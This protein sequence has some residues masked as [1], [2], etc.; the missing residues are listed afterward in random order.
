ML[1][2]LCRC[3]RVTAAMDEKCGGRGRFLIM[4]EARRIVFL[5]IEVNPET[6]KIREYGAISSDG[7]Q[8]RGSSAAAFCDLMDGAAYLIG[9]NLLGHDLR[10]L[11]YLIPEH[12][13]DA[14]MIDTLPLSP[15]LFPK[16]PYHRLLKDD[17]L[18][19][20]QINNPLNDAKKARELFEDETAA[21]RN[22]PGAL[23]ALYGRL[24]GREE[25]FSGFM[26]WIGAER[27]YDPEKEIRELFIGQICDHAPLENLIEQVPVELAYAL[28]LIYAGDP[29]SVTPPWV[30]R[31]YPKITNVMKL[32]RGTPCRMRCSYCDRKLDI[33]RRLKEIFGFDA[34]RTYGGVPLQEEATEAAV[35]GESLLAVFPTGGG[36][37]LTFQLPALIAGETDRG[38]TVVI[39]PLQS[40]M[41]DQVDHLEEKGIADA[42]TINGLL[43]PMERKEAI[44][45]VA[46]GL[47]SI[48]YI[49]PESLRSGTIA[50]LLRNR[51]VV[52]FVVDEA[53][54]FSAWGQDFRVDYLYIG[55]FIR[56]LQEEKHLTRAIPVSCFTATAKQKVI[57]DIREYFGKKLGLELKLY[58]TQTARN[59][60]R[61]AVLYKETDEE[62]YQEV[63]NLIQARR[64]PS[65]VY[66]SRVR[67]TEQI[68]GW[69]REDGIAAEAY[70]GRMDSAEKVRVQDAFLSDQVQVIVA[71]SAFGMGVDKKDVGLVIHYDIS[72]S[73][74]NYVQEAGRAGRDQHMN[75]ECYVLFNEE[76]LDKHFI[77]LNQTKLSLGEIQ[78]VWKAVKELTRNRQNV[79]CS[80]LEIARQ[81]GWDDA[82]PQMETRVTSA[83]AALENARYLERGR[84]VPHIYASSIQVPDMATAVKQL[85]ASGRFSEEQRNTARRIMNYLISRK[86]TAKGT[87]DE[88]ESRVDYLADRLGLKR[89]EVVHSILLMR[90][91]GMLADHTDLTAFIRREENRN[92]SEWI[93]RRFTV[94]ETFMLDHM[95]DGE[96]V[97]LRELNDRAV[98]EGIRTATVRQMKTI[99]FFWTI[100]GEYRK[101]LSAD[102]ERMIPERAMD[103]DTQRQRVRRRQS[104]C[105][106]VVRYLFGKLERCRDGDEQEDRMV[107]FSVKELQ[108]AFN[109]PEDQLTPL[110]EASTEDV[111]QALL[112]LSKIQALTLDGGFLVAYNAMQIHRL[113]MDN[114]I[115][116]KADDYRLLNE[117]YRQRVQ[118]IHI[119]GEYAHLM[120][121][122]YD[123][124]LR[125]VSDYFLMDYRGFLAKY[126]KGTRK[127]EIN[128]NITPE[129][130]EKL[131]GSLSDV[132]REIVDDDQSQRIV[133]AAGPGSG[134]TRLL[135]H[136]LASLMMLED[137][138]HEQMLMLT[139]SRAAATEFKSRLLA[140]I[141]NAAHFVEIRTF[142]SYCFDLLGRIGNLEETGTVVRSAAEMIRSGEV[143]NG[144]ITRSVLV[145]DEAQDMDADENALVQALMKRNENM[146][147]I[148]V[149]DDD[150]NIFGFRGSSSAYMLSLVADAGARMT[151]MTENYRSDR[152]LVDMANAFAA[153]IRHRVKKEKIRAVSTETGRV[154]VYRYDGGCLE[155][156]L[157]ERLEGHLGEGSVCV[158]TQTNEQAERV[159][160][161]LRHRGIRCGLIQSNDGFPLTNLAEIRF[162]FRQLEEAGETILIEDEKWN[163]ARAKLAETWSESS[164]LPLC[165]NLL[166]RF[167]RVNRRKYRRD[168]EEYLRESDMED[169]QESPAGQ[170]T[171]ST[172]H[173]A[174]GREF[175]HVT[176]LLTGP[177]PREDEDRRK[178][179]VGLT[180]AKKSLDIH[181]TWGIFDRLAFPGFSLTRDGNRREEPEAILLRLGHRDV[182]LGFFL[183]RKA[184]N[185]RL[186]PGMPL[187]EAPDGLQDEEGRRL[188][189]FSAACRARLNAL[190][191]QGYEI[192]DAVIRCIVAWKPEGEPERETAALL[193]DVCLEKRRDG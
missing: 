33:H 57:S 7:R 117:F 23:R 61:Y 124:A 166:D 162:F 63:R 150:Q 95:P 91:E 52:R 81:A 47:A 92:K 84:N 132:Q 178:V 11:S 188:I 122:D 163:R 72:D 41:K 49:S 13:P 187:R 87:G 138:K 177:E 4:A 128:R 104:L 190:Q 71:T 35:M 139:F 89:E 125:F 68:A 26:D 109:E 172:I 191:E 64:C 65:I 121:R 73:L 2:Y 140:L 40:L 8:Y 181:T 90:E 156:P 130:Y 78:Q 5:D 60:L 145:I 114:R 3:A 83:L 126:F 70:N 179:Y 86:Y 48:L 43:D 149:G 17:K 58:T 42:V 159:T 157:A 182:D 85:Q 152:A 184:Q 82:S 174:K 56:K 164:C 28:A 80:P 97:N 15:L 101:R 10:Y 193:P 192:R 147:V 67:R 66:V 29:Y 88:A 148:A 6:G 12:C 189:R 54:C 94:L 123:E 20:E 186:R 59:N 168:L 21:F 119:V 105:M 62:K 155:V 39:S 69:L 118:Q 129:K 18:Q 25:A 120:V 160:G 45:R 102:E 175:D 46:N 169:F 144:K 38:L 98:Q 134:K 142:H 135:V 111:E 165:L 75:A 16:K 19:A 14:R 93:L 108:R 146:R 37:S 51:N 158:L 171:V 131:F 100:C 36:K 110:F 176:M 99:L 112:Y 173:K 116:Y 133:V 50:S 137:V 32:L 143:E 141:G 185:L 180:R 113:E 31:R 79:N 27:S 96:A 153:T 53:H 167:A 106:F 34:F 24:L 74:E 154:Q 103:A 151:E 76:D 22:L 9:H 77:L 44:D 170:V 127:G 55:D 107:S 161:L 30:I 136:K 183:G 1:P 115:K